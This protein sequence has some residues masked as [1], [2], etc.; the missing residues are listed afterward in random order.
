MARIWAIAL[1]VAVSMA[2]PVLPAAAAGIPQVTIKAVET[3]A[4]GMVYVDPIRLETEQ[5]T[6]AMRIT[7]L[8]PG[9]RYWI[10]T[11]GDYGL[12]EEV[13][14]DARFTTAANGI[15][16][17]TVHS[18]PAGLRHD[19]KNDALVW[20]LWAVPTP[21]PTSM[22]G[23][24][25]SGGSLVAT[26]A[27]PMTKPTCNILKSAAGYRSSVSSPDGRSVL[28]M[29]SDGNLVLRQNHKAVWW[30]GTQKRAGNYAAVQSDGNFVVYSA[31]HKALWNSH[32]NSSAI[33][34]SL[35]SVTLI[36][37]NN[38][39][40]ILRTNQGAEADGLGRALWQTRTGFL[41]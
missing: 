17:A 20:Q 6:S 4:T 24:E 3:C 35:Q 8:A 34:S 7:G 19:S 37:Y 1:A 32:T 10:I 14:P 29:Q 9:H 16:T 21:E 41:R 25:I 12:G 23:G 26:G 15:F 11:S 13:F 36:L 31:Q 33:R 22:L 30:T 38:G 18:P 27:S 40:L 28:T 5:V 39:N 2:L